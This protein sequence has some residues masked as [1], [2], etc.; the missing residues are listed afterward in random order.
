[1]CQPEAH[2]RNVRIDASLN[3]IP[4]IVFFLH[5]HYYPLLSPE[6]DTVSA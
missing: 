2:V 4:I 1:M 5:Y 3:S 6:H